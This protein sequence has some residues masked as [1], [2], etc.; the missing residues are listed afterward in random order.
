MVIQKNQAKK[1]VFVDIKDN[2][3][4]QQYM[5]QHTRGAYI[6][7]ICQLEATFDYSIAAQSKKL[8]NKDIALFKKNGYSSS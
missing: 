7:S 6:A 8:S 5:K 2:T 3:K 4:K 1:L